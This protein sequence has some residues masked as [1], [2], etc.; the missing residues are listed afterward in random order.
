M[1]VQCSHLVLLKPVVKS[2]LDQASVELPSLVPLGPLTG[3]PFEWNQPLALSVLMYLLPRTDP[4]EFKA[5]RDDRLV[6]FV[7]GDT[8]VGFED[9]EWPYVVLVLGHLFTERPEML[10]LLKIAWQRCP[11]AFE[12]N[13]VLDVM[14]EAHFKED[15]QFLLDLAKHP[16]DADNSVLPEKLARSVKDPPNLIDETIA[17][18]FV[19][20]VLR[21]MLE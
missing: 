18:A 17:T 5:I 8:S 2:L 10:G 20:A 19:A 9:S 13:M 1:N 15:L 11:K 4:R 14:K 3:L 16:Y 12:S 7:N 21:D 6:R